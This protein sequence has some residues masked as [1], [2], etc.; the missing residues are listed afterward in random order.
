MNTNISKKYYL[1]LIGLLFYLPVLGQQIT[2][3]GVI[4]DAKTGIPLPGVSVLIKST[5][6]GTS[7]DFDGNYTIKTDAKS[8]LQFSFIGYKTIEI[9]VNGKTT[10]NSSLTEESNQ[11]DEIVVIGYGTAK[12]K[13]LTGSVASVTSE[14]VTRAPVAN[15]AQAL[16]GKLPGVNVVAQDGRPGANISIRVRGGGS[17]SQSNEPLYIVDG[18]QVSSISNIPGSQIERIDVLKDAS[19]TAIYGAQG[20]NGVILVTTKSGKEGKTKVTYDGYT[21]FNT[22]TGYL[23]VMNG[24]DYIKYNWAYAQAIGDGYANAWE[25]LWLIGNEFNGSNTAGIDYYKTVKSED[26]S[27]K[28]YKSSFSHNHDFN[29]TSGNEKTKY[30]FAINHLDQDGMK[31][32]SSY[33]RSN[34]NFKLDQKL[35]E[36][37]TFSFNTRYSQEQTTGNEG[38]SSGGGSLLTSAYWF[39]PIATNDILGESDVTV[40]TQLGDYETLLNDIYSPVKRINDYTDTNISRNLVA[41]TAFSWEII[42]GL[43]AKTSLGLTTNWG[44]RKIWQ[45]AIYQRYVDSQG[46]KTFAGDASINASEGWNYRWFNTLNYEVQGLGDKHS[47]TILGG[48]EVADSHSEST[49]VFGRRFPVSFNDE[50]AFANMDSYDHSD[51]KYGGFSSNIGTANRSNSY[52]GRVNYSFLDKYLFTATFRADGSSRFA[53]TNRWAYFPAAAVGWRISDEDFMKNVNW[54]SSLKLRASYGSVGNDGINAG[55]WK[56][57]WESGGLTGYS[58]NEVQQLSYVPASTLNNPNLKWETTITRNIGLD[59]ALFNNKLKGTI[60]VYKNS[61]KDLLLLRPIAEVSGFSA[62]YD[63]LGTTSN[64]GIEIS[65]NGDLIKTKDFNLHGSININI[66]KGNVDKLGEGVNPTYSSAWG[67]INNTPASGDYIFEVGK[68]VGLVRG[69]IYDGWYTTSDFDYNAAGAGTYTLKTGVPDIASGYLSTVY[70]T[71]NHK[72]GSQTAY[73]GVPK[74]KDLNNDGIINDDDLTVI[75]NMN[76]KHTGG[77]NLSGNY[78]NFDFGFDFNWSYGNDIYNANHLNAYQGNKESGLFRNR[79]Q[80]LAGAYKIYDVINGQITEVVAPADLDA[81]NAN[82]TTFIPFAEKTM[83]STYAIEDGS[84]LR[85]NTFTLG[86]SLPESILTKIG[87]N[88]L[89]VYGTIYNVFTI[90]GYNG[91]DPEVNPDS[92]RNGDYPTPGL[93]YGSYPRPRSFTLGVN[94]AF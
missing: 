71:T 21:Q 63:N 10:I 9:P 73:P 18:F 2:V 40:N 81:L 12:R 48:M 42:K 7:T 82:A 66:N 32:N 45:G 74:Y 43:T 27:K 79:L 38:T 57:N 28:V 80:E 33:K 29:I 8:T 41:N 51:T 94:V 92:S 56:M 58:L 86:Y 69:W 67:G 64:K 6:N 36:K 11:L 91:L 1:I 34:V 88:N 49:Y 83:T 20:A 53:P 15:V 47:L 75:G 16:Q 22:P 68:P 14:E 13:D 39:R 17:I 25:K 72:P 35:G 30:V 44:R 37:V 19:A 89:R 5:T 62:M 78:K 23:P 26:F 70:G 24:Y 3:K 60:D 93:D 85:L 4:K 77:F 31:I 46:N 50:R 87:F 54:V 52:F 90:T 61:V 55:L 76:P 59:F 84:F 65:L